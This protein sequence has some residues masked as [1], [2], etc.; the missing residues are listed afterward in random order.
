MPWTK[1][2]SGKSKVDKAGDIISRRSPFTAEM[3]MDHA[4]DIAGNWRSSHGYPLHVVWSTLRNR[5]TRV[6]SAAIVPKRIKRLPSVASKLKRFTSMQLSKM[7]DLGGCRAVLKTVKNVN[8]LVR[9]YEQ[10]PCQALEFVK[11]FD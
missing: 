4:F 11:K 9:F 7:Q 2:I 5:A 3:S 10:N 8:K 6:D 1:P